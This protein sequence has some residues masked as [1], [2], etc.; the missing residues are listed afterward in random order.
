VKRWV[1][2]GICV[3]LA[4]GVAAVVG[5]LRL[6]GLAVI[7]IGVQWLCFP[8]AFALRTERFYDLA[9]SVTYLLVLVS[10]FARAE[11][12][13][14]RAL[15]LSLCV[16]VWAVRLG[17]FLARRVHK[18]G[19]DRRFDTIKRSFSR[20]AFAWTA[21][22]LWVFLTP[23]PVWLVILRPTDGL[24]LLDGVGLAIWLLGFG[25][26]VVA[27]AQKS[28]FR[29]DPDNRDR[30]IDRGLWAWSR[31]PNYLGEILLWCGVF[32]VASA[33]LVGLEWLAILSPIFVAVLLVRGSGIPLLEASADARWGE[34]PAYQHYK[35]T[36]P[37]LVP[38]L[39]RS[40]RRESP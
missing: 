39:G 34:D 27:D 37:V 16:A 11:A 20:F 31:H 36:T 29:A 14:V 28:A 9:G 10:A 4:V 19:R 26:E 2:T 30:F 25:L 40:S 35:A 8:V 21:Q 7:A 18:A 33:Q 23:L 17:L 38:W 6:V 22:G 12:V 5:D 15:V 1:S 24:G 13:S 32:V 3:L